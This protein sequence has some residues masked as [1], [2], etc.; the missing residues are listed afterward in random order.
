[1]SKID[2]DVRALMVGCMMGLGAAHMLYWAERLR[3]EQPA[4]DLKVEGSCAQEKAKENEGAEGG[5]CGEL[6]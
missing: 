3:K 4:L 1:M 2:L 6:G 5:C